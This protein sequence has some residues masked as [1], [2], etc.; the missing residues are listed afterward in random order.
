M[1]KK[2][3]ISIT[4]RD[5]TMLKVASKSGS[6]SYKFL[7]EVLGY[8]RGRI[9]KLKNAGYL[10]EHNDPYKG[11][12]RGKQ[13]KN[14]FSYSLGPEGVDYCKLNHYIKAHGG[15]NGAEHTEIIEKFIHGLLTKDKIDISNIKNEKELELIYSKQ[16]S[17][18]NRKKMKY[19]VCDIGV[20][21]DKGSMTIYEVETSNYRAE[22]R[23]KHKNFALKIANVGK[24]NYKIIK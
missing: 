5:D 22:H 19:S 17:T 12:K 23:K 20:L 10:V 13:I 4:P 1:N 9:S 14:R 2:V 21:D 18:A 7:T 15:H 24:E 6:V 3:S 11:G 8:D 16:I